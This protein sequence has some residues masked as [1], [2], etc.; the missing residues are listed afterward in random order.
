MEQLG[1]KQDVL[2]TQILI[3]MTVCSKTKF[4]ST[5]QLLQ[6][7]NLTTP[8]NHTWICGGQ[9][10]NLIHQKAT[11]LIFQ[12]EKH[13]VLWVPGS[14]KLSSVLIFKHAFLGAQIMLMPMLKLGWHFLLSGTQL[15]KTLL[16]VDT[17]ELKKILLLSVLVVAVMDVLLTPMPT[18][19][20][21]Q[22][23]KNQTLVSFGFGLL[24]Q[25]SLSLQEVLDFTAIK[26]TVKLKK[27]LL[28]SLTSLPHLSDLPPFD[29]AKKI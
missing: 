29:Q 21:S 13:S 14:K 5:L 17:L 6:V 15:K 19:T 11:L 23:K 28:C 2:Q 24:S 25:S 7:S 3:Q 1:Q 18:L 4:Y 9:A 8:S 27:Q 22:A 26:K 12:Q 20:F 10:H 16:D